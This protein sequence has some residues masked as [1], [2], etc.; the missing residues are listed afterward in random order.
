MSVWGYYRYGLVRS[1]LV[2]DLRGFMEQA[3]MVDVLRALLQSAEAHKADRYERI[4][5]AYKGTLKFQL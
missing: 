4:L 1:T 2:V 5:L 3:S